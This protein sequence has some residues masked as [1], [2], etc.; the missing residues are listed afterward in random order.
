VVEE[1][2]RKAAMIVQTSHMEIMSGSEWYCKIGFC[3]V[4][5]IKKL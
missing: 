4:D 3:Q 1:S 5:R 2:A